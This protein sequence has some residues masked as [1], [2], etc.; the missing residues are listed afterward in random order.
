MF[1]RKDYLDGKCSHDEYYAQLVRESNAKEL[2]LN[3]FS[4]RLLMYR[5]RKD[6]HLNNLPIRKWDVLGYNLRGIDWKKYGDWRS[7]AGQVCVL[8]T[9]ARMIVANEL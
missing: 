6:R 2:V 8:K 7:E 4:K 1:T 5:L 9:A 3:T